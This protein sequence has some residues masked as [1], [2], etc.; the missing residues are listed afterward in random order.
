MLSSFKHLDCLYIITAPHSVTSL[1]DSLLQIHNFSLIS[2]SILFQDSFLPVTS[3]HHHCRYFNVEILFSF[4]FLFLKCFMH[5]FFPSQYIKAIIGVI[6]VLLFYSQFMQSSHLI[7][8]S[9][10]DLQ[11][12]LVLQLLFSFPIMH[13]PFF[14]TVVFQCV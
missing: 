12:E 6:N 14:G 9:I 4:R 8:K 2:V 11:L 3:F 13:V 10:Q 1:K 7:I 5:L